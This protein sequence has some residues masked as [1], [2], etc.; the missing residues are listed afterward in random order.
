MDHKISELLNTIEDDLIE[1]IEDVS[2]S[3]QL[4]KRIQARSLREISATQ[5]SG[6]SYAKPCR[7]LKR[8]LMIAAILLLLTFSVMGAISISPTLQ[9]FFG[10]RLNLI[11]PSVQGINQSVSQNGVT[12]TVE[13]ALASNSGA[14]IVVHLTKDDQTPFAPNS[15]IKN[16]NLSN[17]SSSGGSS[18][19]HAWELSEDHMILTYVANLRCDGSTVGTSVTIKA[20]DIVIVSPHEMQ[21]PIDLSAIANTDLSPDTPGIFTKDKLTPAGIPLEHPESDITLSGASY[22]HNTLQLTFENTTGNITD[23]TDLR[24]TMTQEIL[25]D[26]G[27]NGQTSSISPVSLHTFTYPNITPEVLDDLA[28]FNLYNT[29]DLQQEGQW[30]TT[31]TLQADKQVKGNKKNFKTQLDEDTSLQITDIELSALGGKINGNLLY[32]P[33]TDAPIAFQISEEGDTPTET[34][35]SSQRDWDIND[36]SLYAITINGDKIPLRQTVSSIFPNKPGQDSFSMH[37]EPGEDLWSTY[38]EAEK[39]ALRLEYRQ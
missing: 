29:Y 21:L 37:I 4:T 9:D 27:Y 25:E 2:V 31:F 13:T 35:A 3:P 28:L 18:W 12:M 19:S 10:D 20:E 38:S 23:L 7:I 8:T 34:T 14:L 1:I 11:L 33:P 16:F 17:T 30:E 36:L 39:K 5:P 26:D 24:N 15:Q 6:K 22:K 32:T